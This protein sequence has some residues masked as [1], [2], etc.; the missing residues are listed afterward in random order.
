MVIG[1]KNDPEAEAIDKD[2]V[3]APIRLRQGRSFR[4]FEAVSTSQY[5]NLAILGR[6]KSDELNVSSRINVID[7]N[8]MVNRCE[9]NNKYLDEKALINSTNDENSSKIVMDSVKDEVKI[10]RQ[11]HLCAKKFI[12]GRIGLQ[13]RHSNIDTE[14]SNDRESLGETSVTE[15]MKFDEINECRYELH[16]KNDPL[17]NVTLEPKNIE[18]DRPMKLNVSKF[19]DD[20]SNKDANDEITIGNDENVTN[21]VYVDEN[22]ISVKY[23]ENTVKDMSIVGDNIEVEHIKNENWLEAARKKLKKVDEK[24]TSQPKRKIYR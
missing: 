23:S 21:T 18:P 3:K 13:R 14:N 7:E 9:I 1:I 20:D 11:S 22:A 24:S 12:N 5:S 15:R 6:V 19:I 16:A 10:E 17:W 8:G 2:R 4:S